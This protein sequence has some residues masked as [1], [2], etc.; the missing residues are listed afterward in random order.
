MNTNNL[1]KRFRLCDNFLIAEL[2]FGTGLNFL[3]TWKLWQKEKKENACL[4]YVS[5]EKQP[6]TK[7]QLN[8]ILKNFNSLKNFSNL[9]LNNLPLRTSGIH[10]LYFSNENIKL[11]LVYDDF[12]YLKKLN[13][14][15]DTWFPRWFFTF[16]E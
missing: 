4:N 5:F 16:K 15:A 1:K 7:D 10:E 12:D 2:G 13:F 9:L 14:L 3:N 8:K 6:L 11:T